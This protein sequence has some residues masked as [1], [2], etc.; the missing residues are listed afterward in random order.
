M[1]SV[2]S[3]RRK[4]SLRLQAAK[5]NTWHQDLAKK[6]ATLLEISDTSKNLDTPVDEDAGEH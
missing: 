5:G 3:F 4:V 2:Q 6:N 1:I